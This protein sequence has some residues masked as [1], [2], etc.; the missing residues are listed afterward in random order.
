MHLAQ[1][2][3]KRPRVLEL[4]QFWGRVVNTPDRDRVGS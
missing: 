1:S 3:S 4:V 2:T